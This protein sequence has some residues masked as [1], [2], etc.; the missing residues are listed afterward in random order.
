[1][2]DSGLY[3]STGNSIFA[4][5]VAIGFS[6]LW[7]SRR[8]MGACSEN[9]QALKFCRLD[10]TAECAE[11]RRGLMQ[12]RNSASAAFSAVISLDFQTVPL[13]TLYKLPQIHYTTPQDCDLRK[14]AAKPAYR[15]TGDESYACFV[16]AV[17]LAS[18]AVMPAPLAV[19]DPRKLKSHITETSSP[20]QPQ[21]S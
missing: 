19:D 11:P 2:R 3:P 17:S 13:H 5:K 18:S 9:S 7:V 6:Y 4:P 8:V 1:M 12:S 10:S 16:S 20:E 14:H 21:H 15:V